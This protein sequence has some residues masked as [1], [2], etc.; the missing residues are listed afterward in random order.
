MKL[1]A[2]LKKAAQELRQAQKD[3]MQNRGN[4]D[5]GKVVA[6]KASKLEVLAKIEEENSL[7]VF[8]VEV[9]LVCLKE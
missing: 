2:E 6:E 5:Y 9:P 3:Y 8:L 7:E 1:F 4:D